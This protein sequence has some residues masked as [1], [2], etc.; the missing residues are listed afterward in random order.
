[1][2]N[3]FHDLFGNSFCRT[4]GF[5]LALSMMA[6]LSFVSLG[7]LKNSSS[8]LTPDSNA[9]SRNSSD[10]SYTEI[11]VTIPAEAAFDE[12][13]SIEKAYREYKKRIQ[14]EEKEKEEEKK[15]AETEP[16]TDADSSEEI[17]EAT[18]TTEDPAAT[19]STTESTDSTEFTGTTVTTT[20]TTRTTATTTASREQT[21]ESE[22]EVR[23]SNGK[24]PFNYNDVSSI[25]ADLNTLGDFV[26]KLSPDLIR[27]EYP[28]D[29]SDG[30]V[31]IT[32]ESDSGCAVLDVK[33]TGETLPG[34][35]QSGSVAADEMSNWE[36][37]KENRA[38]GCNISS[39]TWLSSNFGIE[40]VRGIG[41]GTALAR[42]TDSYLCVNGGA[43]TLYKASDVI[44][45]QSKL[46]A[47]LAAENLYTFVGGR[48]Y[49]IGSYLDKYY[50]GR[51]HT[52]RFE[53]CDYIIQYGCNSIM[54]HNYT[55]GSWIIEYAVMEDAVIGISFMNKSYYR[56]EQKTAVSTN[57]PSSGSESAFVVTTRAESSEESGKAPEETSSEIAEPTGMPVTATD[58]LADSAAETA[59]GKPDTA[60][61]P[62]VESFFDDETVES[63]E[64]CRNL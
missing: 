38:S 15:G 31:K 19:S 5:C 3:G 1:M 12:S 22:A 33:Q 11:T 26:G 32:L 49:S 35:E 25:A 50:N 36:W 59:P 7:G 54:D 6:A 14:K 37:L 4:G 44:E 30:C 28:D 10:A 63:T 8:A 29:A 9:M 27:W 42:L 24:K 20:V 2:K 48:V 21:T 52:F 43:T 18:V 40:A 46:N 55:T 45:D 17:G 58:Q 61:E 60:S 53:N 34:A 41:V 56:S 62:P 16:T 51:E 57:I 13:G 64:E 39:V 47:I 23:V